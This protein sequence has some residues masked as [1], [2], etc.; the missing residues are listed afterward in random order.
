[1]L[2]YHPRNDTYNCCFRIISLL[3]IINKQNIEFE[4]LRILDFYI[5]FPHLA[6]DIKYPRIEGAIKLKNTAKKLPHPYEKLPN[7]KMLFSEL[8]D[9]QSQSANILKSLDIISENKDGNIVKSK[10]FECAAVTELLT[11]N[12]IISN[13]FINDIVEILINIDMFGPGGLKFRTG[14][15]EYRYDAI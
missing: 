5:L 12:K 9:Y 2:I 3:Y 6:G 11:N 15:M 1:M 10:G 8:G 4:R 13:Q 14:L 7:S